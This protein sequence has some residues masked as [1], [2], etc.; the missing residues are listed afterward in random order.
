MLQRT[1]AAFAQQFSDLTLHHGI[2]HVTVAYTVNVVDCHIRLN[3]KSQAEQLQALLTVMLEAIES[4]EADSECS[5]SSSSSSSSSAVSSSSDSTMTA[6]PPLQ[7]SEPSEQAL[8]DNWQTVGDEQQR[9]AVGQQILDALALC[10]SSADTDLRSACRKLLPDLAQC[11]EQA[12]YRTSD[13]F[14][15]YMEAGSGVVLRCTMQQ[16]YNALAARVGTEPQSTT[17]AVSGLQ[18]LSDADSDDEPYEQ[19]DLYDGTFTGRLVRFC[20]ANEV[21][22]GRIASFKRGPMKADDQW[23]VQYRDGRKMRHYVLSDEQKGAAIKA[24]NVGYLLFKQQAAAG[25]VEIHGSSVHATAAGT[26]ANTAA[27][28]TAAGTTNAAAGTSDL[29]SG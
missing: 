26:T 21:W 4:I 1:V 19:W 2:E 8:F 7:L 12:V 28:T 10:I 18:S 17:A 11:M 23:L 20:A 27:D 9:E 3:M 29:Q 16:F 14:N 13:S 15:E 5:S 25:A 6:L 22:Y 24:A